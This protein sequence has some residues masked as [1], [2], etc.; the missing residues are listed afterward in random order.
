[1]SAAL[2]YGVAQ[3]RR[4]ARTSPAASGSPTARSTT[5]GSTALTHYTLTG[6]LAKSSNVGTIMM[7]QKVGPDALRRHAGALRPGQKTGVGLPGESPGSVP[8]MATWSGSTF[9]NLPDR[10]GPVDDRA[11]DGRHVPGGRQQRAADPAADRRGHVD[12]GRRAHPTPTPAGVQVVSPQTARDAADDAHRGHAGRRTDHRGTGPTAAI[13]GYQVAGKTGTAQQVDPVVR[14][15]RVARRTG[16]RSPACSRPRTPSTSSRS[17]ST[18]RG[19]DERRAAVPRHRHVPRPARPHP[20]HG[21]PRPTP[22]VAAALTRFSHPPGVGFAGGPARPTHGYA[23]GNLRAMSAAGPVPVAAPAAPAPSPRPRVVRPVPLGEVA[24]V[25]AAPGERRSSGRTITRSSPASRCGPRTSGPATCSPRCPAPA[26]TVPTSPTRPSPGAPSP[27]S[28]TPTGA[29]ALARADADLR[30]CS[31]TPGPGPC[32]ATWRRD[33]YGDPTAHLGVIGVTGTSGKTTVAHLLEAGLAA[34]GRTTGLLGTVGIRIDGQPLPSAFTTP[35][36]PDLQALF[37]VMR[38]NGVTDAVMEVSSHALALGRVAGTRFAV[39]AFT[40]LSQDHLDFHHDMDEYFA[41][42]AT[43]FD[44]RAEHAVV[45]IDD[46]WGARLAARVRARRHR[47]HHRARRRLARGR[48]RH[49]PRRRP[50]LHGAHP[51]RPGAGAAAAAR[52]VQ[53][54][55]RAGRARL[56]GRGGRARAPRR[57]AVRRGHGARSDAA[58]RRGPAVPRGRRLRAQARRR[59]RAAGHAAGPGARTADHRCSA[60][61]ATA[62]AASAR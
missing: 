9:G 21:Q 25:V 23:A 42:K 44:G 46:D 41:A 45:C 56:P 5:P 57:R 47:G 17:C 1:M 35:E 28:P 24:A 40:N 37:A 62:T 10:A 31:S 39:G 61:A 2:E 26:R 29:A 51:G 53:R 36:A 48:R 8:P 32:S 60:A 30:P 6:I 12:T 22:D 16:S 38:E 58:G 50:A 59:R 15:L 33:V 20:A 13:P 34:A 11:A 14:L 43:L 7:A 55:Q 3:A 4:R 49:R 18:P 52:G 19:R 54:G 27:S